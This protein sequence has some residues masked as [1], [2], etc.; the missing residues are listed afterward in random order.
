MWY[1]DFYHLNSNWSFLVNKN[2]CVHAFSINNDT[3]ISNGQAI[4]LLVAWQQRYQKKKKANNKTHR[5]QSSDVI[6]NSVKIYLE[7]PSVL[8]EYVQHIRVDGSPAISNVQQT[9]AD[10]KCIYA[11]ISILSRGSP[12]GKSILPGWSIDDNNTGRL[13]RACNVTQ[14]SL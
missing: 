14:L 10:F 7:R 13:C 5:H 12:V 2:Q 11:C 1:V 3:C 8:S 4:I 9:H 6:K